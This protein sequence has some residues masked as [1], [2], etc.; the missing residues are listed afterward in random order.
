MGAHDVIELPGQP[1]KYGRRALVDAWRAAGSPWVNS[2]GR[3]YAEQKHFWDG[4]VQG[5]PGFNPADNPDDETQR[6]AHVRFGALDIDPTPERVRRLAAAGLIR[7]YAYEPWHWELPSIRSYSIVRSLPSTGASTV[8]RLPEGKTMDDVKM[9][10]WMNGSKV[11]GRALIVPGTPWAVP[12]TETGATYANRMADQFDTG[13]S[14]EYTK[15]LFDAFLSASARCAP[16][17]LT[18]TTVDAD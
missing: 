6:L 15:S 7:P 12:W 9:I 2:A 16:T 17:V 18:I 4:W 13:S 3:L 5:L 10:H 8:P 14:I 11:G 1:G